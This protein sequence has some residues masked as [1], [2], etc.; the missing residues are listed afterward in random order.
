[1]TLEPYIRRFTQHRAVTWLLA[2]LIISAGYLYAFPQPNIFYAGVVLLHVVAGVVATVLLVPLLA[3]QFRAGKMASRLGWI[4]M[5]GGAFVGL[6][7]IMTGT[8]RS[9][10]ILMYVHIALSLAGFSVLPAQWVGSREWL[11]GGIW[12]PFSR[13][14]LCV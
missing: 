12:R 2:F 1:M 14:S 6:I 13:Y 3:H 10:W 11:A 5:A 8:P 4:L 9:Q 7:L